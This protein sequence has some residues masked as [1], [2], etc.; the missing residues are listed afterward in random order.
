MSKNGND[1]S[2]PGSFSHGRH[3]TGGRC[4][5]VLGAGLAGSCT[6]L[7][8]AQ[9]GIA[10]NLVDRGAPMTRASLHNEGKIHLGYTYGA[11][12]EVCTHELL[13]HGSLRFMGDIAELTGAPAA[14][15]RRSQPFT[16]GIPFD[17]QVA[18]TD[19]AAHFARVDATIE[20]ISADLDGQSGDRQF[21][22]S[23][24]LSASELAASFNP[25]AIQ[26]AIRTAEIAVEPRQI[27]DL[28]SEALKG[29]DLITLHLNTNVVGAAAVPG[30]FAVDCSTDG[31]RRTI[32]SP[33][34]VNC[35]WEDRIRV[36]SSVGIPPDRDS[37]MRYK[38]AIRFT[39]PPGMLSREL[40]SATFV[41]GPYGDIVN[42]GDGRYYMSWYP[43][44][45]LAETR[46]N[47]AADLYEAASGCDPARLVR[48]SITGLANFIPQMR[49]LDPDNLE[50]A[51]GGGVIVAHGS[52]DITDPASELHQRS[53]I[54]VATH[55]GWITCDTGK[56]CMAPAFGKE[57]ARH[58]AAQLE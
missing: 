8:L 26:A 38:A 40:P 46:S 18:S 35:L 17:T 29:A 1:V 43:V 48:E 55:G 11:D 54:G 51:L 19:L 4:V 6:A 52:T 41:L 45:K 53:R 42:H 24:G 39:V 50:V 15:I 57:A 13:A 49:G 22:P 5:T 36:D 25:A 58:A 44:G 9:R 7:A 56:Y 47:D 21:Y 30:G 23:S 10:V 14:S 37:L 27:A 32:T 34:V 20:R 28:I 16:Y 3:F 33:V 2:T 31:T 12:P